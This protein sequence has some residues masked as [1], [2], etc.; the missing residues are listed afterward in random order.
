MFRCYA[1]LYHNHW[2]EP[3][4]HI[5]AYKELNTCFIHFVNVGK[6]Y[7]LLDE[8]DLKPMQ[9]LVD[10]WQAQGLLPNAQTQPQT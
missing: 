10:I 7:A 9:P 1:H 6:L 8:K 2:L 4:Y 5:G 3:F